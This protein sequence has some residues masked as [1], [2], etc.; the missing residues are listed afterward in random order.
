MIHVN[1]AALADWAA[2]NR[3]EFVVV[4]PEAPLCAGLVDVLAEREI[5]AFGPRA[6]GARIEGSKAFA[7]DG[8]RAANVPTARAETVS[9]ADEAR[10]AIESFGIPVVLK[11]DGLAAG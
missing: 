11:A 10:A 5:P 4:G 1:I 9:T 8:M 6:A 2:S 7:K 3:I